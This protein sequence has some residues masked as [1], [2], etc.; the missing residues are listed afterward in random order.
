V[1]DDVA[2]S[3]ETLERVAK[4]VGDPT[5]LIFRRLFADNPEAEALFVGDT[6]D[7]VRGQMVRV[8]IESL[9]DFLGDRA[10]GGALIQ[11][12]RVNHQGLGVDPALFDTFY[13]TLMASFRDILGHDWTAAMEDAWTRVVG[14]LTG[15]TSGGG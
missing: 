14:E 8:T 4:R 10:Y 2:I 13:L 5:S 6:G 3:T 1:S 9:L 11:I 15:R 12:E 7:L